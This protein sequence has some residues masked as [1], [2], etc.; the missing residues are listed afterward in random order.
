MIGTTGTSGSS[1]TMGR[2]ARRQLF[3]GRVDRWGT[4]S[5]APWS[6]VPRAIQDWFNPDDDR[7]LVAYEHFQRT[8]AWPEGFLPEGVEL[9]PGWDSGLAHRI[10]QRWLRHRED[11]RFRAEGAE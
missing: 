1:T 8:G 10:A 6:L 11:L 2:S 3:A 7:H 9:P 4:R 5:P